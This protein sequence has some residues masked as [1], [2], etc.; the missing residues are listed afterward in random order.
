[1]GLCHHQGLRSRGQKLGSLHPGK[2]NLLTNNLGILQ[3]ETLRA[4]SHVKDVKL[5]GPFWGDRMRSKDVGRGVS[6]IRVALK[7]DQPV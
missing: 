2:K 3:K 7:P 5:C 6:E 4:I 1:L